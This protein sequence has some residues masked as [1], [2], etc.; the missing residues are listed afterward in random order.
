LEEL[1]AQR[2]WKSTRLVDTIP[3]YEDFLRNHPQGE[4]AEQAR[5]RVKAMK[6]D[7]RDWEKAL[8]MNT[9]KGYANFLEQHPNSP[10]AEEAEGKSSI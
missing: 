10:F 7:L 9:I 8:Q 6:A 1:Y 3:G 5:S 4:L 2:D